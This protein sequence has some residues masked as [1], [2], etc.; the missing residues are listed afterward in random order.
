MEVDEPNLIDLGHSILE[1]HETIT[2]LGYRVV[3]RNGTNTD[4]RLHREG[5]MLVFPDAG[6]EKH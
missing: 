1:L 5:N 4:I 2:S 6:H 3:L